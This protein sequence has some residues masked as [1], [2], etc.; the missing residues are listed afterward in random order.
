MS[1]H[2]PHHRTLS[3]KPRLC[4]FG[5]ALDGTPCRFNAGHQLGYL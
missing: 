3:G 2:D 5:V 4:S 1:S